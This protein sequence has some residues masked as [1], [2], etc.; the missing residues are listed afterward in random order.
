MLNIGK[1]GAKNGP[2]AFMKRKGGLSRAQLA[3]MPDREEL[4]EQLIVIRR[5][6][7]IANEQ[8][9]LL[10]TTVHRSKQTISSL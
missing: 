5:Q 4:I 1:T 3:S 10:R 6:L 8:N 7:N 9:K 2:S